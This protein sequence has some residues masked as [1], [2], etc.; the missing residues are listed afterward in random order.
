[1]MP[2]TFEEQLE[3]TGHLVFTNKG[4]SM[5]P[6]LRQDR[7]LMVLEKKGAERCRKFDAVL[8]KR[9]NGQYVLHRILKVRPADYWIVGDNCFTGENIREDQILG[10]LTAVVRDGTNIP[11]TDRRYR[12]YV[13][14]WCDCYPVRFFLLRCRHLAGALLRKIKRIMTK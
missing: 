9:D 8:F 11:V 2:S 14:L 1:M 4:T 10:V 5:L 3:Q 6:L 13:H 7:D 12:A